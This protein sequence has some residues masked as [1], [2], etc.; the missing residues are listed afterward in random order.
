MKGNTLG[1]GIEKELEQWGLW[2]ERNDDPQIGYPSMTPERRLSGA[3]LE[4]DYDVNYVP[5]YVT[6]TDDRAADID[7]VVAS[8]PLDLRTAIYLRYRKEYRI[9]KI[10][11]ALSTQILKKRISRDKASQLLETGR[12]MVEYLSYPQARIKKV[13]SCAHEC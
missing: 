13:A 4:W 5:R 1:L 9:E 2:A 8:L 11:K 3:P 12:R 6:I 7:R 10:A